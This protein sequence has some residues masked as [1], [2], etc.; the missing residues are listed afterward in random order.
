MLKIV[1]INF[2]LLLL[3]ISCAFENP[4][5]KKDVTSQNKSLQEPTTLSVP[6]NADQWFSLGY[7]SI[8]HN[9]ILFSEG[10]MDIVVKQSASPSFHKFIKPVL[11]QKVFIQGSI[12][13]LI[14]MSDAT[15]QGES[16]FDDFNLRVGLVA[17]GSNRL[18]WY[19]KPFVAKWVKDIFSL[20]PEDQGL[21]RIYFLNGVLSPSLLNK[22][23]IHPSSKYIQE[24][25]VWLMNKTGD[26][27]YEYTLDSPKEIG[28]LWIAADGDDTSSEFN[29][30][31]KN[32]SLSLGDKK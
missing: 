17:T 32:I 23:R 7:D 31:I 11:V 21:D 18:E 19:E 5:S 20:V 29:L 3:L 9:I 26:F 14:Y 25:Y 1:Q 28:A 16:G 30:R 8:P 13:K 10:H 4:T 27:S 6:L 2:F 22:K 12:D 24:N 15:K